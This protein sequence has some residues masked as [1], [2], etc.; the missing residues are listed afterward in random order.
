MKRLVKSFFLAAA[1]ALVLGVQTIDV[2]AQ[3]GMCRAA[4]AASGAANALNLGILLL[5]VPPVAI[6][7]GIFIVAYKYR[8]P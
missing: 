4:A 2:A 3:C 5:L 6:F 8:R 7:C 1:V